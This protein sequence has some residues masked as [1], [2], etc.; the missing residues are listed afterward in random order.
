MLE[1][2]SDPKSS[3]YYSPEH[4]IDYCSFVE[5]IKHFEDGN[6]QVTQMRPDGTLDD[7]YY[8]EPWQIWI[9]SAIHGFRKK[10]GGQRMVTR[11]IVMVPRKNDKSGSTARGLLYELCCTGGRAVEIVIA[12]ATAEQVKDT[13]YYDIK[14][15]LDVE[16]DLVEH[17][18]ISF[19]KD[20][21][22]SRG[23]SRIIPVGSRAKNLDGLNPSV[24]AFEEG[25]AGD[26]AVFDV[27]E[28]AFGSKPNQLMKMI[29]TAGQDPSGPAYDLMKESQKLLLGDPKN[30]SYSLFSAFYTLDESDYMDPRSKVIDQEKLLSDSK[31]CELLLAKANPMWGVSLDPSRIKDDRDTA[32]RRPDKRG[33]FLRTRYNIWISSGTKLIE[34]SA[35]AAC[36]RDVKI[37]ECVGYP[38]WVA[39]DLATYNDMC[40]VIVLFQRPDDTIVAFPKLFL[41]EEAPLVKD[42]EFGDLIW[43]WD[44]EEHLEL[45]PGATADHLKV[46][47]YIMTIVEVCNPRLVT[48]DPHQAA[49]LVKMLHDAE[50]PVATYANNA[51]NMTAPTD[52]VLRRITN[53]TLIHDGNPVLAWHAQNVEGE[54]RNNGSIM[55]QRDASNRNKKIDGFVALVMANGVRMHPDYAAEVNLDEPKPSPYETGRLIS[56]YE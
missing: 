56:P 5:K 40:A 38:C 11:A 51:K 52:D 16:P 33:E 35:W 46:Y 3:F 53:Q 23:N 6:W 25:H 19:T 1:E 42:P 2:A 12:A 50:V 24:V 29:T 47:D 45:T 41:P 36:R 21:G 10:P 43:L 28:S 17:Y 32:K 18:G 34:P 22:I 31:A 26:K 14:L 55:P 37:E 44:Q 4:V 39:V 54:R 48:F 13:L 30:D 49:I 20:N 7:G 27:I 9:E 8:M 15:I